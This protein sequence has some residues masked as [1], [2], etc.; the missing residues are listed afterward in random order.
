MTHVARLDTV[1]YRSVMQFPFLP[2][3]YCFGY[4]KISSLDHPVQPASWCP[5]GTAPSAL[6]TKGVTH[7]LEG[8]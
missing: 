6:A 7:I 8:D 5:L 1:L 4:I 2:T 3:R